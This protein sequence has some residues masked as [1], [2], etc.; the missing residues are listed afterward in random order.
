MMC[1]LYVHSQLMHTQDFR[2]K[3]KQ[4]QESMAR[5]E[6]QFEQFEQ[7]SLDLEAEMHYK[8]LKSSTSAKVSDI[9]AGK[10]D[11]SSK[12]G[13]STSQDKKDKSFL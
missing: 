7:K 10:T 12:Q 13:L 5:I 11:D 6:E 4:E 1:T 3:L 9:S 2:R 8:L